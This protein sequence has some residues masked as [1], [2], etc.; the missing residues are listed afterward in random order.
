[1]ATIIVTLLFALKTEVSFGQFLQVRPLTPVSV[2]PLL[3]ANL[4]GASVPST[5]LQ[6]RVHSRLHTTVEG[7]ICKTAWQGVENFQTGS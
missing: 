3:V 5:I 2:V 6:E 1:M 4:S 7:Q